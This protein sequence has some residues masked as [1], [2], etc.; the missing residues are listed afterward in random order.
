VQLISSSFPPG[1]DK[2]SIIKMGLLITM[3]GDLALTLDI[4]IGI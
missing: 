2:P 3:T 4:N 1:K